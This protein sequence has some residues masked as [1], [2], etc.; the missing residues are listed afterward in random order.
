MLGWFEGRPK[1]PPKSRFWGPAGLT[2]IHMGVSQNRNRSSNLGVGF[3]LEQPKGGSGSSLIE[4]T[5][6]LVI[7]T[8]TTRKTNRKRAPLKDTQMNQGACPLDLLLEKIWVCGFWGAQHIKWRVPVGSLNALH[9]EVLK[10]LWVGD[11]L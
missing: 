8:G 6:C 10:L 4:G 3:R 1:G 9:L 2:D 7:D 11:L 5:S